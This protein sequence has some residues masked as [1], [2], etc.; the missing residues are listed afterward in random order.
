MERCKNHNWARRKISQF[1][2]HLELVSKHV[3][4]FLGG[5]NTLVDVRQELFEKRAEHLK[6]KPQNPWMELKRLSFGF[7]LPPPPPQPL[8]FPCLFK[9]ILYLSD[10]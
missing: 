10:I 2:K 9:L 6:S 7:I 5:L 1:R 3:L 8:L 4:K